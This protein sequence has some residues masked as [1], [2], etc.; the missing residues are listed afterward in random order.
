MERAVEKE[1]AWKQSWMP[2]CSARAAIWQLHMMKYHDALCQDMGETHKRKG[3][4][5]LAETFAPYTAEDYSD[6]FQLA[7]GHRGA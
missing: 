6:L 5:F 1:R 2:A 7:Q 3:R 4:N